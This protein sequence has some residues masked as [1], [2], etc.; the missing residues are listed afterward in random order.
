MIT[1]AATL[2]LGLAERI[3]LWL[4]QIFFRLG[5]SGIFFN[6][7]LGK[8]Q[9]WSQT[10][11]LFADEY[12]VPVLP[13]ALAA[14]VAASVEL[15][16][17]VLLVLGLATRL[18]TLPMLGMCFVIGALV[19]PEFWYEQVLWAGPLLFLLARGPGPVSLDRLLRPLVLSHGS[20]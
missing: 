5:I 17:P 7:G 8:I 3:P 1:Q 15:A 2:F 10:V 14:Y 9:S 19:Y 11:Q 16:C 13:P 4:V 20:A 6:A 12:R 18:A